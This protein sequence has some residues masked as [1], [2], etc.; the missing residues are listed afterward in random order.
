MIKLHYSI[1][2]N[3]PIEKVWKTMLEDA[4]YR[5]WTSIFSKGSYYEGDWSKGSKMKFL[6]PNENGEL[7]G[8]VSIM[9]ENIPMEFI[10]IKH[11]G[12]INNGVEDTTSDEVMA[13]SGSFENYMFKSID[14]GTTVDVTLE[15]PESAMGMFEDTWPKAL[16]LLKSIVERA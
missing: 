2:I 13:W 1:H 8:M 6:G 3:A 4:T 15:V 16:E 5:E 7:G 14:G 12:F 11:V 10:S 9:E